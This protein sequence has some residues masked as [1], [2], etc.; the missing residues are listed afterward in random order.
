MGEA[1]SPE[2]AE[3]KE[4]LSHPGTVSTADEARLREAALVQIELRKRA[5]TWSA[6]AKAHTEYADRPVAW[7]V[8]KLGIPESTIRWS[9]NPEYEACQCPRCVAMGNAGKPHLWDGDVDP[10]VQALDTLARGHSVAVSSGTASGKTHT[11]GAC[12]TLWY[13]ATHDRS[14]VLSVAP[15]AEQLLLNLWKELGVLLPR[16]QRHFPSATLLTGKL[17]MLEG[18]GEQE[19]WAATAF[20]AGVGAEEEIAQR[21]A[22]FHHPTMWW[23]VEDAP[24]VDNALINTIVNTAVG[25]TNIVSLMGNPDHTHDTLGLFGAREWVTEIR[26]SSLDHPNIVT[27]RDIVPG[28]VSRR[29]IAQRLADADGNADDPIYLSRVRGIAPTQSKRALIRWEWLEAAALRHGDA[30]LR[31]GPLALGIDVADSPSGDKSAFSRW[32]G[33]VCIE[34]ES[35]SAR[36]ASEVGRMAYGEIMDANAPINPRNVGIDSVGVG[37]STVNELRRLGVRIRELSGGTRAVPTL[38]TEARTGGA[39]GEEPRTFVVAEAGR[40]RNLRSQIYWRL[41]EDLR[42]GRIGLPKNTQLFEALTAIEYEEPSGCV[43]LASKDQTKVRIGRSPDDADAVAY[44]NWVRHRERQRVIKKPDAVAP[45]RNRD[46]GLERKLG[47]LAK[48]AKKEEQRV[49]RMFRRRSA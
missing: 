11:I 22:G 49:R 9:L 2:E 15:K 33:A 5:G 8:E 10:L 29:S 23:L 6:G 3:R 47:E 26:V 13:L 34:V 42:L 45:S 44:G 21:L 46:T 30:E 41:R 37:A 7:I 32:Q 35:F 27:G 18:A 20:S 4:A 43:T 12:G 14:I 25:Q 24:G 1:A 17:R 36:D 28:A 40:Y 39:E 19:V 38:D 31:K 16:F 48:R